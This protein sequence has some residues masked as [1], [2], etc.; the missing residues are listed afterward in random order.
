MKS[1]FK[2]LTASS[3]TLLVAILAVS[4]LAG[5]SKQ[6]NTSFVQYVP[7]YY[8]NCTEAT[9][10]SLYQA[11]F[12]HYLDNYFNLAKAERQYNNQIFVFKNIVITADE[13][14]QST[15]QYVWVDDMLQCYFMVQGGGDWLKAGDAVDIVGVDSGAST[16]TNTLIFTGCLALPAGSVQ[17]PAAGSSQLTITGGY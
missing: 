16:G 13:L 8:Y 12:S 17:L 14:G 6:A 7:P 4:S 3:V 10:E 9:P 2:A 1:A 5:C 15:P 11:Y